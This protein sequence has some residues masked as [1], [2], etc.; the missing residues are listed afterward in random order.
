MLVISHPQTIPENASKDMNLLMTPAYRQARQHRYA[1]SAAVGSAI[2]DSV[3]PD[4]RSQSIHT[5]S[6]IGTVQ[7][8]LLV[9]VTCAC[10]AISVV[11][12][13]VLVRHAVDGFLGSTVAHA[14]D[15][16]QRLGGLS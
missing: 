15:C 13:I 12:S 2:A 1:K 4:Q 9:V 8:S 16:V 11:F 10:I 7:K 14:V 3:L 6:V 5:L